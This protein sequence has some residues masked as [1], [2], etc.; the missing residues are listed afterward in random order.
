MTATPRLLKE[1]RIHKQTQRILSRQKVAGPGQLT[2][3]EMVD[4]YDRVLCKLRRKRRDAAV[5]DVCVFLVRRLG[6]I[7]IQLHERGSAKCEAEWR[8]ADNLRHWLGNYTQDS[9]DD[10]VLDDVVGFNR[11]H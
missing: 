4:V 6:G 10:H 11:D 5:F 9:P 1:L 2:E 8:R 7:A 3:A